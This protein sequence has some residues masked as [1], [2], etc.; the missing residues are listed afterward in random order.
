MRSPLPRTTAP[1]FTW[2]LPPPMYPADFQPASDLP[3]KRDF[4]AAASFDGAA[5]FL[6][7]ALAEVVTN[8]ERTNTMVAQCRQIMAILPGRTWLLREP[9]LR[10]QPLPFYQAGNQHGCFDE[11]SISNV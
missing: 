7:P 8:S 9:A 3:S 1:S 6:S 5:D 2:I 4:Q 11:L 10:E